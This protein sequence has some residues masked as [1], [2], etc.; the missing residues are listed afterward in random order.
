MNIR[1]NLIH[2]LNQM[3]TVPDERTELTQLRKLKARLHW[4]LPAVVLAVV[5][6]TAGG[7]S[8]AS[9]MGLLWLLLLAVC[10]VQDRQ[11][12]RDGSFLLAD[13]KPSPARG[14]LRMLQGGLNAG[15]ALT[16]LFSTFAPALPGCLVLGCC[17]YWV[18]LAL[19][20]TAAMK[21]LAAEDPE[22]VW[23]PRR[24]GTV[25][26]ALLGAALV[27]VGLLALARPLPFWYRT[28]LPDTLTAYT[29]LSRPDEPGVYRVV[30]SEHDGFEL[31]IAQTPTE[32][33][34]DRLA[35][36]VENGAVTA[37]VLV[38]EEWRDR[39]VTT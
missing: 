24:S 16:G 34:C 29:A 36:T 23:P 14:L 8:G 11:D 2:E 1:W 10:A 20:Q 13:E 22:G 28:E 21:R 15:M 17:G 37:V 3:E 27:G 31:Y 26:A 39:S 19:V 25:L 38:Q 32:P 18:Y 4:S 33:G 6:V 12:L 30:Q 35:V 9:L 5:L 7:E